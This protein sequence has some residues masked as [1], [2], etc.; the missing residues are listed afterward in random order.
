M[1]I[2]RNIQY[3]ASNGEDFAFEFEF[4]PGHG[5]RVYIMSQPDYG[6]RS[7]GEHET[8]RYNVGSRPHICWDTEILTV[9]DARQIA[10]M[11]AEATLNYIATGVFAVPGNRPEVHDHGETPFQRRDLPTLR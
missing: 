1:T 10:A 4:G 3:R 2:L 7:R 6:P 11:W 5:W 9:E 8:H